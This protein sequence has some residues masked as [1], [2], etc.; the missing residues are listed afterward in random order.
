MVKRSNPDQYQLRF[1]PGMRERLKA[2]ADSNSRSLNA[3]IIA[4]LQSIFD[5]EDSS[6]TSDDLLSSSIRQNETL[7]KEVKHQTE[8]FRWMLEQQSGLT[9]LL[10]AIA[11]T[12]GHLGPEL[13]RALRQ[14]VANKGSDDVGMP[15]HPDDD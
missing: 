10:E 2:V 8:M 5:A 14:M 13:M 4:R 9:R 11:K 15:K 3:E 12:D 6:I 7:I 1:P